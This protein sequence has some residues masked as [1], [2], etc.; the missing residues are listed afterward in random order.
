MRII[1]LEFVGYVFVGVLIGAAVATVYWRR[2]YSK[3]KK[4]YMRGL[5]DGI[6]EGKKDFLGGFR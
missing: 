1:L 3:Y 4:E 6:K 5:N 2:L